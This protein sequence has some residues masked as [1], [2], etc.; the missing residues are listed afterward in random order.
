MIRKVSI[1]PTKADRFIATQA[2]TQTNPIIQK[3]LRTATWAADGH[4][5]GP[6]AAAIWLASRVGGRRHRMSASHFALTVAAAIA[7]PKVIKSLIDRQR[8]DRCVVGQDRRGVGISGKPYDSFPSGHSVHLGAVVG[9]LA[10]AYPRKSRYIYA[11]GGALA[12]TRIAVLAHWPTDVL[13][14]WALGAAIEKSIRQLS[15]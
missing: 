4:V 10:W 15:A 1:P 3:C 11:A 2:A 9:A 8:P 14:G 6:A 7:A 13:A 5:L 12:A